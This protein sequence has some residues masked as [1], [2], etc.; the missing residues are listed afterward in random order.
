MDT[1]EKRRLKEKKKEHNIRN[2]FP[3]HLFAPLIT[4]DRP[5]PPDV[6]IILGEN[7]FPKGNPV[8]AENPPP[9]AHKSRSQKRS[10]AK[11]ILQTQRNPETL[12]TPRPFLEPKNA[13]PR[14]N[15]PCCS[16]SLEPHVCGTDN[17]ATS[18]AFAISP[19]DI[20]SPPQT[21]SKKTEANDKRK[22]KIVI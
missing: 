19:K 18:S 17:L 22:G 9:G 13:E 10:E 15:E 2:L 16:K 12:G 5:I 8:A 6:T 7:P 1:T 11:P 20:I 4:R 21:A 3:D 14:P